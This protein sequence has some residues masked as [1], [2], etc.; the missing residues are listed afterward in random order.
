MRLDKWLKISRLIK[1]R[2]V[3][4]MACDQGRVLIND[5]IAKSSAEVE[6]DVIIHIELGSRALTVKVLDIP[7]K[8]PQASDASK[9]YEVIEEIKRPPEILEWLPSDEDW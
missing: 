2:T 1:R 5:R 9:L 3:A 4:K 8:T 7:L 6:A